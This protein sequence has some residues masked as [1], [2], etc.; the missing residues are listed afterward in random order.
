VKA[1]YR[2]R[3]KE[4][5]EGTMEYPAIVPQAMQN[6]DGF[7]LLGFQSWEDVTSEKLAAA[8]TDVVEFHLTKEQIGFHRNEDKN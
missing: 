2:L 3:S 5:L 1:N 8:V 7:T 6:A 4:Q